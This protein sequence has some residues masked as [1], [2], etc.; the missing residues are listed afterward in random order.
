MRAFLR[1]RVRECYQQPAVRIETR[2]RRSCGQ[3]EAQ[4]GVALTQLDVTPDLAG[5]RI[6]GDLGR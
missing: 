3:G 2:V 5:G 1:S 4:R 6:E